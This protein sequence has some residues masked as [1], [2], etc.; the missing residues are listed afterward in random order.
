MVFLASPLSWKNGA[1]DIEAVRD[2]F[3]HL[4]LYW[5]KKDQAV[6]AA[7]GQGIAAAF[8]NGVNQEI[9]GLGDDK[10]VSQ[11]EITVNGIQTPPTTHMGFV[12]DQQAIKKFY[13]N[14][15]GTPEV[16]PYNKGAFA[17]EWEALLIKAGLKDAQ[18][19]HLSGL[20]F[21]ESHPLDKGPSGGGYVP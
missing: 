13:A 11:Q 2:N 4:N 16:A 10:K 5:D 9:K 1:K 20:E 14:K 6:S 17:A 19:T 3:D 12:E 18:Q 15:V 8:G 7:N 21:L